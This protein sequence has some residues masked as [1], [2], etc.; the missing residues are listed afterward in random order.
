MI[1]GIF[2]S[3]YL[4][5]TGFAL[6]K[7]SAPSQFLYN[8]HHNASFTALQQECI[9]FFGTQDSAAQA[10]V[11]VNAAPPLLINHEIYQYPPTEYLKYQIDITDNDLILE[12]QIEAYHSLYSYPNNKLPQLKNSN[13][14]PVF[15]H[16][17]SML[18]HYLKN[19][20]TNYSNRIL[21]FF[22]HNK[23]EFICIRED[24]LYL[25]NGFSFTSK[26]DVLYG[27]INLLRQQEMV[28]DQCLML[29]AGS[30]ETGLLNFLSQYIPLIEQAAHELKIDIT[31]PNGDKIAPSA[32]LHLLA[33]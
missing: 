19:N 30:P 14:T 18:Y 11:I 13:I 21:L 16:A 6:L 32:C 29:I 1:Q 31:T 12:D 9:S 20:Y 25:I 7:Q 17:S 33:L 4:Y 10:F 28:L 27:I 15:R 22:E 5:P 24:K 8:N 3:I 2:N 23:L 26:H